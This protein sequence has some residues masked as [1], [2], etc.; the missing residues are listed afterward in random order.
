MQ[1]AVDGACHRQVLDSGTVD[2]FEEC[3]ALVFDN[4]ADCSCD[5]VTAAVENSAERLLLLIARHD[6]RH[7]GHTD[8]CGQFNIFTAIT[9]AVVDMSDKIVPFVDLVNDVWVV[10]RAFLF[11]VPVRRV[12]DGSDVDIS[13]RHAEGIAVGVVAAHANAVAVNS[14]D[15]NL[16]Q[17]HALRPS[18]SHRLCGASLFGI[19]H[20]GTSSN[21]SARH[22]EGI[23]NGI[24]VHAD[25]VVRDTGDVGSE[26][27]IV[28]K[29]AAVL[30]G[31]C[32]VL[33]THVLIVLR[34]CAGTR[35][36]ESDVVNFT[37]T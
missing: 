33:I 3:G 25:G 2:V 24:F 34:V 5:G 9:I 32:A 12:E 27:I 7:S 1:A 15:R 22:G 17:R 16:L 6:A 8:V 14:L 19:C 13:R 31:Q 23:L 18:Q 36:I 30:I 21:V 29:V 11:V 28:L 4:V 35:A 20:D 10:L 26:Y 37:V